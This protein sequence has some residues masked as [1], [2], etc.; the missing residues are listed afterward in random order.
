[1]KFVSFDWTVDD[2]LGSKP[3]VDVL[4]IAATSRVTHSS[5]REPHFYATT[6]SEY[7]NIEHSRYCLLQLCDS[8]TVV[9]QREWEIDQSTV[10]SY[11]NDEEGKRILLNICVAKKNRRSERRIVPL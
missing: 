4:F 5:Y 11:H 8:S 1:M 3:Q 6:Y 7:L 9:S 10:M 2:T